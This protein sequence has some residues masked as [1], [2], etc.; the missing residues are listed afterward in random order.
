MILTQTC[1]EKV[2]IDQ[3]YSNVENDNFL[4]PL[5]DDTFLVISRN[6]DFAHL[7]ISKGCLMGYSIRNIENILNFEISESGNVLICDSNGILHVYSKN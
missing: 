1:L 4:Y 2:K 6:G 3:K 7:D 5:S